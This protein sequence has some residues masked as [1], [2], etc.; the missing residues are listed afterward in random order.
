MF[1]VILV[2]G[3]ARSGNSLAAFLVATGFEGMVKSPGEKT[4]MSFK[5]DGK[6][7]VGKRPKDVTKL[8]QLLNEHNDL[9]VVC[10]M[11]DP[12]AVLVSS[13]PLFPKKKRYVTPDRWVEAAESIK[14]A[15]AKYGDR[16]LVVKFEDLVVDPN[17]VQ[18]KIGNF[19]SLKTTIPF[20]ECHLHMSGTDREF[21]TMG[22][23]RPIDSRR[24]KTW[25]T[26]S[27]DIKY[28]LS[29]V[30]QTPNLRSLM[31]DFGYDF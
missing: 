2:T 5:E 29:Q 24:K 10:M 21:R 19:F 27:E 31:K 12:R 17:M 1:N 9:G 20:S 14:N 25:K 15:V 13:H 3:C 28:V 26:S 6:I 23:N 16:I 30:K 18:N 8:T 4:P 22:G 11:R 7:V